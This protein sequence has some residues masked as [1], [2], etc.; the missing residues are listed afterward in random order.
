[1]ELYPLIDPD[2]GTDTLA[3]PDMF[4][5][6]G[7]GLKYGPGGRTFVIARFLN[8]IM[9]ELQNYVSAETGYVEGRWTQMRDVALG[10]A[11]A[12]AACNYTKIDTDGL[13]TIFI[14]CA[15]GFSDQRT[16]Y[17]GLD[18]NVLVVRGNKHV[19]DTTAGTA[20]F[21]DIAQGDGVLIA[22]NSAGEIWRSQNSGSTWDLRTNPSGKEL[23]AII[24][25][26][27]RFV[28][29]GV[30]GAIVVSTDSGATFVDHSLLANLDFVDV[31]YDGVGPT[32]ADTTDPDSSIESDKFYAIETTANGIY[33]STIGES[34][35]LLD[36]FQDVPM[37]LAYA[38]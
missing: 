10:R 32:V 33:T 14:S 1:M 9:R 34:W 12:A 30:D 22:V 21:N 8:M 26:G 29:V 27:A 24:Y 2:T 28:A 5:V 23:K 4:G 35:S 16:V 6:G 7:N 18:G 17:V 19:S 11:A 38:N 37:C 25:A 20:D 31:I 15:G 13:S 3:G 36:T